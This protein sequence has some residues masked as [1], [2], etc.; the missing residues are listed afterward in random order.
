MQAGEKPII[1]LS[2]L[3]GKVC[4]LGMTATASHDINAIPLEAAYPQVGTHANIFNNILNGR[5]IVRFQAWMNLLVLALLWALALVLTR[6]PRLVLSVTAAAGVLAAF[7]AINCLLFWC[8]LWW[9]DLFYPAIAFVLIYLYGI[10]RRSMGEKRKRELIE[11]E[12]TIASSIQKSFLPSHVPETPAFDISFFMRPAKHVGGDLYAIFRIGESNVG[13]MLGDVSGKGTP[14]ALFMAKSV[15]EFKFNS[16]GS[17]DPAVVLTNMNDSLAGDESSGLFVTVTYAIFMPEKK[18][19]L[20]SN[21]GHLPVLKVTAAGAS[22]LLMPDGGMP[23]SL[24]PGVEFANLKT[25]IEPGDIFLLYSDGISESKNL[26]RE[27]YEMDR[28]TLAVKNNR[29]RTSK[30][31]QNAVLEDIEKFVGSA[32]QHDDM[33]MIVIK[34]KDKPA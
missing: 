11:A 8:A 7:V 19:A 6:I 29:H 32:P 31:I 13:T 5:F 34:I 25:G 17:E 16:R 22:E 3:K 20:I 10:L 18:H 14:A 9:I 2:A 24:M 30:E 23:I 33:T 27:D 21:G 26:K 12:L 15:S 4:F 28:L 1:D